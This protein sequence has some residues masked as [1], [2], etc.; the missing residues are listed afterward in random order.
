METMELAGIL[1][2]VGADSFFGTTH[3]AVQVAESLSYSQ[4][5]RMTVTLN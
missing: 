4:R 5:M 2:A 1:D 3:E